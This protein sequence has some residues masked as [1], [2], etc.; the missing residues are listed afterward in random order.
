MRHSIER[1]LTEFAHKAARSPLV[2]TLMKPFYYLY[3][4]IVK[5]NRNRIFRK[6]GMEALIQF[7][8]CMQKNNLYYTLAFGTM[9][10]AIREHG[11]INH[12]LDIDVSMFADDYSD[13]LR[14]VLGEYGFELTHRFLVDKG[15]SGREETYMFKGVSIDIFFFYPPFD[16]YPYC[17][18]FLM[19]EGTATFRESM[20]NY[21]SVLPRRIELPIER[22]RKK[23]P[24]GNTELFVPLNAEE[25]LSFRY[26][27]DYM[28]PNPEWDVRSHDLHIVEWE[29]KKGIFEDFE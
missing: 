5:N 20:N 16:K 11:F 3:K 29:D 15:L 24:F 21:G 19:R 1:F 14:D 10:G 22:A 12:D 18:D 6:Y 17:C 28:I 4:K 25:I 23:V 27:E 26:G 13:N 7:D 9:L 2:K 8:S